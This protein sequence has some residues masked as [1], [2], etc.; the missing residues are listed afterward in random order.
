MPILVLQLYSAFAMSGWVRQMGVAA[1][2]KRGAQS[3]FVCHLS[4]SERLGAAHVVMETRTHTHVHVPP[5]HTHM[6]TVAVVVCW[7]HIVIGGDFAL[8][9]V[10]VWNFSKKKTRIR[11]ELCTFIYNLSESGNS[12]RKFSLERKLGKKGFFLS[13]WQCFA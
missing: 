7:R 12:D 1:Y 2:V 11:E 8:C 10:R 5:P 6:H 3:P 4:L 9:S 13:R